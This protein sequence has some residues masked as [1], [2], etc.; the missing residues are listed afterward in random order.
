M[1]KQHCATGEM[2]AELSRAR[3]DGGIARGEPGRRVAERGERA[4]RDEMNRKG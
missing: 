2:P 3:D 4:R 1:T